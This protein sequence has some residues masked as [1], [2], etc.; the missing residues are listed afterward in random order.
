VDVSSRPKRN[1]DDGDREAESAPTP[2]GRILGTA[3]P[4]QGRRPA[5]TFAGDARRL[6]GP[7]GG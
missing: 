3:P 2:H 1:C 6:V 5:P 7:T 4:K